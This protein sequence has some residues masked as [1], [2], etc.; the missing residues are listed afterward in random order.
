MISDLSYKIARGIVRCLMW[1]A[2]PVLRVYGRENLPQQG[3][4]LICPNHSGMADPIW[5]IFSAWFTHMPTVMAKKELFEKT[6]LGAFFRWLGAIPVDRGGADINAIKLGL[7]TLKDRKFLMLFP[8]GTRVKEGQTVEAKGGAILLA[9]R[10]GSPIVPVYISRRRRLFQPITCVFGTPYT[11][12]TAGAKA[13]EEEMHALTKELMT[14][15][16]ALEEVR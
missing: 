15:I 12:Q 6:V 5:V 16:Y 8:E 14:K 7:K 3:P 1:F 9:L 4:A 13:T 11:P 2:H 10:T